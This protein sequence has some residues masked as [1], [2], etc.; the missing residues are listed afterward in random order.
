M[1]EP[2]ALLEPPTGEPDARPMSYAPTSGDRPIS[3]APGDARPMSYAPGTA[4]TI[5]FPDEDAEDGD[6]G[7]AAATTRAAKS[8]SVFGVDTVW[9]REMA[10]LKDIQAAEASA[11]AEAEKRERAKE[12]ARQAKLEG[13]QRLPDKYDKQSNRKTIFGGVGSGNSRK[14]MLN[15]DYVPENDPNFVRPISVAF[16]PGGVIIPTGNNDEDRDEG[17]DEAEPRTSRMSDRP[18]TLVLESEGSD[19]GGVVPAPR[20]PPPPR[21]PGSR[22]GVETWFADSDDES[23]DDVPLSKGK[24]KANVLPPPP[25]L[26]NMMGGAADSDSDDEDV[27]LSKLK[28]VDSDEEVPLSQLRKKDAGSSPSTTAG[29]PTLPTLRPVGGESLSLDLPGSSLPVSPT[30][31]ISPGVSGGGTGGEEDDDEPLF[32]RKARQRA[33]R[34]VDEPEKT[35]EEI[36]DDL[37]LGWKHAGAAGAGGG[38]RAQSFFPPSASFYGQPPQ[39]YGS[40]YG[41]QS[42]YGVPGMGMPGM[43]Y[44]GMPPGMPPM[45]PM[46]G[47]HPPMMPMAPGMGMG[48]PYPQQPYEMPDPGS[49]IDKWRQ[50]VA[51]GRAGSVAGSVAPSVAPS[52]VGH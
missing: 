24:G 48:M 46:G 44:G 17:D 12:E 6:I 11:R 47:M 41:V 39:Q 13:R 52:Q 32:V 38:G 23:E 51:P 18:P 14:S 20:G 50:G 22:L 21:R 10:K 16:G 27:P 49:N 4:P 34:A 8:R 3:Y 36:E 26:P 40:P 19:L 45:S 29:A 2:N 25:T 30:S 28:V 9:E 15:P 37:P 31:P 7:N 43:G 42:A 1:I 5:N 33:T 35:A